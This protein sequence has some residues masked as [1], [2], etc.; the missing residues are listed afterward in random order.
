MKA[1][2][3]NSLIICVMF[4]F[5]HSMMSY[6]DNISTSKSI[7]TTKGVL[8]VSALGAATYTIPISCPKGYGNMVPNISLVYNSQAG[9]GLVGYGCNIAGLSA[10]TRGCK[11]IYHDGKATGLKYQKDD[12]YFLD[13]KRLILLSGSEGEEGAVYVPEGEPFTKVAF[14][15]TGV[16]TWM[17]VKGNDGITLY[18][19]NGNNSQQTFTDSKGTHVSAWN[20]SRSFDAQGRFINYSYSSKNLFVYPTFISYGMTGGITNV[21]RFTYENVANP[22]TLK[23]HLGSAEGNLSV[24]LKSVSTE[25]NNQ[26]F[27][28]YVCEY[29]SVSD[30]SKIRYSRLVKVTESNGKGGELNPIVFKWNALPDASRS[31]C[32]IDINLMCM[33]GNQVLNSFYVVTNDLNGDGINDIVFLADVDDIYGDKAYEHLHAYVFFSNTERGKDK[34]IFKKDMIVC[35][36]SNF[37]NYAHTLPRGTFTLDFDGD[38]YGDMVIPVLSSGKFVHTLSFYVLYGKDLGCLDSSMPWSNDEAPLITVGDFDKNGRSDVLYIDKNGNN[39]TYKCGIGYWKGDMR[40]VD[41]T[42]NLPEKPERVFTGDYN[43]DGLS[44]ILVFYKGGYKIF[45]NEGTGNFETTFGA[46]SV[47][48]TSLENKWQMEQGDFNGDGLVDFIY[49]ENDGRAYYALN[50]GNGTFSTS[51]ATNMETNKK[52]EKDDAHF[53]MFPFDMDGDGKTDLFVSKA[54]YKSGKKFRNV[55]TSWLR[56]DGVQ[57]ALEKTVE[58]DYEDNA[59]SGNILVGDFTGNGQVSIVNFGKNL[60]VPNSS[61]SIAFRLYKSLNAKVE[62]GKVFEITDGLGRKSSV[63]YASSLDLSTDFTD[64][65]ELSF[66]VIDVHAALPLVMKSTDGDIVKYYQYGNLKAHV[67]GKGVLGFENTKVF[68]SAS[69]ETMESFLQEWNQNYWIPTKTLTKTSVGSYVSSVLST[70]TIVKKNNTFFSFL[71][72]QEAIDYD[73]NLTTSIY[74][75]NTDYGYLTSQKTSYGGDDMFK[76]VLYNNYTN[77]NGVNLPTEVTKAQKH[78]DSNNVFVQKSLYTYDDFGQMTEEVDNAETNLALTTHYGYDKFGNVTL[79]YQNGNGVTYLENRREYDATGRFLAKSYTVPSSTVS[80]YTIDNWGNLL[81]AVE[82]GGQYKPLTTTYELDGWGD[83]TRIIYPTGKEKTIVKSWGNTDYYRYSVAEKDGDAPM[84]TTWYDNLGR[85]RKSGYVGI[86]STPFENSYEYNSLGQITLEKQQKG[87]LTFQTMRNYDVRGRVRSEQT[88]SKYVTYTYAPQT[89]VSTIGGKTYTKTYDRWNNVRSVSEPLNEVHYLYNSQGL[90]Q[91]ISTGG[92]AINMEYDEAGNRVLLDDPDAG[93]TTSEYSADGKLLT[94][95]DSR[96]V[97]SRYYYDSLRRLRNED[98]GGVSTSYVYGEGVDNMLLK[99]KRQNDMIE[100]YT[101]DDYGR[102]ITKTRNFGSLGTYEYKYTYNKDNEIVSTLYPGG[103]SVSCNYGYG[104]LTEMYSGGNMIYNLAG[105]DGEKQQ[106]VMDKGHVMYYKHW[107]NCGRLTGLNSVRT[108]TETPMFDLKLSYQYNTNNLLSRI[109]MFPDAESFEYDV[110]DRLTSVKKGN[111]VGTSVK[112]LANGNISYKTNVGNYE[113]G[114]KP[115]AVMS[116]EN[117]NG[118][119][120]SATLTTQFN[121]IGKVS[122]IEDGNTLQSLRVEYGPDFQRWISRLYRNKENTTRIYFDD[123]EK[124]FDATGI[125]EFYYL[126]DYVICK[127]DNESEFKYYFVNKDNLGSIVNAYDFNGEKVFDATYDAW[128]KQTVALD[129]IGLYR[130]YCGHEM[131]NDFD[132]VNMNGRLYD[133]VL[134]RFFSPDNY[135]QMPDN[136]QN[137]N[138]YSYCLNNPLKYTDPSGEIFGIDDWLV[139][140]V[141]IGAFM[142][143]MEAKMAGKTVW[144]GMLSGGLSSIASCGIGGVFGHGVGSVG[145]ELLRAGTHGLASGTLSL[146]NGDGFLPGT[147]SGFSASL[148]GSLTQK[149]HINSIGVLAA[150]SLSGGLASVMVG[151]NY[152][153]GSKIGLN[154]GTFNHSGGKKIITIDG[155]QLP[156]VE[157]VADDL[158]YRNTFG[159]RFLG[160]GSGASSG[161]YKMWMPAA[162]SMSVGGNVQLGTMHIGGEAGIIMGAGELYPYYSYN[163]GLDASL[164]LSA[165]ASVNAN[166]YVNN[167]G[168]PLRLS[169][170]EGDGY[171]IG[172]NFGAFSANFGTG[173][174]WMGMPTISQYESIGIGFGPGVGI[175]Q[176]TSIIQYLYHY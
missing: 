12:A 35:S 150:T 30:A 6:A 75:Y 128:G 90:P 125:H 161:P 19:G 80:S 40:L 101:Y 1:N 120:A 15:R 113:Y 29:D 92:V 152:M 109:G 134:G 83:V 116:V 58:T 130:G 63:E 94:T 136:S 87:K 31:S 123:Y 169:S 70:N 172:A 48:S 66:P 26:I 124:T 142:G 74:E 137:F 23:F 39:G 18:Y 175:Y 78:E 36:I 56:S 166:V 71:A 176:N 7:G 41:F 60:Y 57:L 45:Y 160:V 138:R 67:Q 145:K 156:P 79:T 126:N 53:V 127:R 144:R 153:C 72:S 148:T 154:I 84:V 64:K 121:E 143:A 69:R 59:R 85:I 139:S 98:V 47:A 20:I 24:R 105:Y 112:Y 37:F 55:R 21:M 114:L 11:D 10:I 158:S 43:N 32:P 97:V 54:N 52:N 33:E 104:L 110:L 13:G 147:I 168:R 14:H 49:V 50:K 118:I 3:I 93:I 25:S 76:Q 8:D 111:V 159:Y 119:I 162:I 44:D 173:V 122:S 61:D 132:V 34:Y 129:K 99:Y 151:G 167:S 95:T 88:N 16:G 62:S 146:L 9:Y 133:P 108:S 163:V 77:K 141:A 131:L 65:S 22:N 135:V 157:V 46:N 82:E 4:L 89:I 73:G 38:G 96:G 2:R 164:S 91:T 100:S 28:K 115:H 103:L 140:S 68:N 106:V 81:S 27:R 51:F 155:G 117:P 149:L 174:D 102:M 165:S 170:L 5:G 86:S 17:E 42:L 171:E 107:D